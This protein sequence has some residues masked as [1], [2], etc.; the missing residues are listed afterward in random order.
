MN[1][2]QQQDALSRNL[3]KWAGLSVA[4]GLVF[5]L[6]N[7]FWRGVGSQF[8]GWGVT[9]ALIAIFGQAAARQRVAELEN[10]GLADIQ[11]QEAEKLSRLL[12][13]NAG[14]DVLYMLGGRAMSRRD[15]GDGRMKGMGLGIVLQ[16]LFLLVFDVVNAR[17][18]DRER[19]A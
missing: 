10:P 1:I 5:S 18:I 17:Q 9:N 4:L 13:V 3:L 19:R 15:V 12:W 14:L 2:W 16:A 8:L 6:G 7:K 11:A